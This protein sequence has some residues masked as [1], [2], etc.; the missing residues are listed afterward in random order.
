MTV[1]LTDEQAKNIATSLRAAADVLNPPATSE[2][3]PTPTPTPTTYTNFQQIFTEDFGINCAEGEFF[4]KYGSKWALYND[5]WQDT[6]KKWHYNT[7]TI[8]V[9]NGI[10]NI[11]MFTDG[12]GVPQ[13]C[14]AQPKINGT[15]DLNHLY[16]LARSGSVAVM[17]AFGRIEFLGGEAQ[18]GPGHRG[19]MCIEESPETVAVPL[20]SLADPASD[21]CLDE[22]LGI[23]NQ[24][25][26]DCESVVE[27]PHPDEG[28]GRGD[29]GSALVPVG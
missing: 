1:S 13:V 19:G 15:T 2:P 28:P 22:V 7:K 12:A 20:A 23:V 16:G 26:G 29:R 14:A 25:F 21:R 6:S 11:R 17:L 8:S 24:Q 10:A 27:L 4:S 9:A 5:G 3:V 18:R